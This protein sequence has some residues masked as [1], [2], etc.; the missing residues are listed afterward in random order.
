M[1][2]EAVSTSTRLH[3]AASRRQSSPSYSIYKLTNEETCFSTNILLEVRQLKDSLQKIVWDTSYYINIKKKSVNCQYNMCSQA[4]R[5]K[6]A[7]LT[8]RVLKRKK[9]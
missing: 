6:M 4:I 9:Y 8:T 2:V 7:S 3:G 5:T 1:Q